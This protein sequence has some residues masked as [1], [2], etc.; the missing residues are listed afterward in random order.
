MKI[1]DIVGARPNFMKTAPIMKAM[2]M[3]PGIQAVLVR[4][5]PHYDTSMAG[6]FFQDSRIFQPDVASDVGSGTPAAPGSPPL[7]DGHAADRIVK[8]LKEKRSR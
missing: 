1:I 8:I 5:G 3:R 6:Q 4:T 2:R 7:W